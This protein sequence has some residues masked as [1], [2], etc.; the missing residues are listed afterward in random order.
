MVACPVPH[1]EPAMNPMPTLPF[2]ESA[3]QALEAR[4]PE[5]A[6]EAL[7]RAYQ[8]ALST[9]G[10][11][12]EAVDGYLVETSIDGHQRV[13]RTL[14]APLAVQVGMRLSRRTTTG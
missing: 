14:K 11:V 6:E 4:I 1:R 2:D 10:K 9:A 13:I 5:L 8:Q 3:L 12:I 7:H